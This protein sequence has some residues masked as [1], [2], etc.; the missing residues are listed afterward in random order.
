MEQVLKQTQQGTGHEVM[1][2]AEGVEGLKRK[3]RIKGEKKEAL[4]TLKAEI[5]S[6][7]LLFE[8]LSYC[9]VLKTVVIDPVMQCITLP[10]HS[11]SDKLCFKT[12]RDSYISIDFLTPTGNP[13]K[14]IL[15]KLNL[16]DHKSIL[17][18][19]KDQEDSPPLELVLL[20][21]CSFPPV[22]F[23]LYEVKDLSLHH[24][25]NLANLR[26][27]LRKPLGSPPT[28]KYKDIMKAQVHISR[29]LLL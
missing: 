20:S 29:L 24:S 14:E 9:L 28:D 21:V 5:G 27:Q 10:S 25:R 17:T 11:K 18:D 1:V 22:F 7:H 2:G 4:L 23:P 19:S 8:T 3:V 15:L 6:I 26:G 16:P 12:H 13:I